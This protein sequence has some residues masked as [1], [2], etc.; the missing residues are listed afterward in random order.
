M[1]SHLQACLLGITRIVYQVSARLAIGRILVITYK[2]FSQVSEARKLPQ[3]VR[4][5]VARRALD[6]AGGGV[7]KDVGN[8]QKI[9]SLA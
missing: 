3:D 7:H 5:M 8:H 6:L 2:L 9:C 4:S 1:P